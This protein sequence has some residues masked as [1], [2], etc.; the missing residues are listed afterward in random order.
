M[1]SAPLWW[2]AVCQAL[3]LIASAVTAHADEAAR[4]VGHTTIAVSAQRV[5]YFSDEDVVEARGNVDVAL[6]GNVT[7]QGDAFMMDLRQHRLVIAGHV[8]L[9]TPAGEYDG[10]AVADFL[11]YGR[12]YFVPLVPT[13]DRWT[14][15]DGN[16]AQPAKGLDM[17]GDAFALPDVRN[18][19][20][21]V[22]GRRAVIDASTF[23]RI[24]PATTAILMGPDTP[25]LPG[26]VENF[27]SNP[28]FGQNAL[29][30]ATFDAPYPFYGTSHSLEAVHFRVDQARQNP[31]FA[32]F[33][34]HSVA[35]D[36]AYAVFSLNP[37]TQPMKQWT[38]LGYAPEG[39]RS[40]LSV[41]TQL[42]T[43]QTG[44]TQPSAS[45]GFVDAQYVSALRQSSLLID[46]T[47]SYQSLLPGVA[48]PNHPLV[49]GIQWN[50][51]AQPV[52]R[53]GFTFRL[54]SETAWIHDI[55]GVSAQ[56]QPDVWTTGLSATLGSP[57]VAGPF[58]SS[59]Y[60]SGTLS[61][62]WLSFPNTIGAQTLVVSD[63]KQVAPRLFGV[64]SASINSV[65]TGNPAMT[66]ASPN[67]ATG[68][69]V[70]PQSPNGLPV[71]QTPTT[72]SAATDRTYGLTL[73]WQPNPQFQ[74]AATGLR[75]VYT[76][77]QPIAP[78]QMSLGV[79][80]NVTRTLYVTVGRLYYFNW[81]GQS[82]SPKF[83]FQ[84]S[85]Q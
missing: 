48:T 11:Q 42:F 32:S 21:Y 15:I 76:P 4:D 65:W 47:Q 24:D 39:S 74:F 28:A 60:G 14:F 41:D 34:H 22:S 78:S 19:R 8:R 59:I 71:Y 46:A 53:S 79:R 45:N 62:T 69:A 29:A 58:G 37:A 55:F 43:T 9:H 5:S 27:S 10:A 52:A 1:K 70:A 56:A 30:G 63:S 67:A 82:W 54:A 18:H 16:Y 72:T 36:G 3:L 73:S 6:P 26:Y 25:P 61:R 66:F 80:A 2:A 51:Y 23:V 20:P 84:V 49:L 7:A 31:Y 17:P 12:V 81:M 35:D 57:A 50:G 40:A 13:A 33:E 77:G 85:A 44:L 75:S 68:L 38:L 83:S 64:L